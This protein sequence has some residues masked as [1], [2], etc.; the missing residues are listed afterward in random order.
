MGLR[1]RQA[2][3]RFDAR[4]YGNQTIPAEFSVPTPLALKA[5][6]VFRGRNNGTDTLQMVFSRALHEPQRLD[7]S[8]LLAFPNL[9]EPFAAALQRK[10]A[11]DSEASRISFNKWLRLGFFSYLKNKA[12]QHLALGDLR[13]DVL[14]EYVMWLNQ[15]APGNRKARWSEATRVQYLLAVRN[16]LSEL[17]NLPRW[18]KQLDPGLSLPTH[19]WKGAKRRR[20]PVEILTDGELEKIYRACFEEIKKTRMRVESDWA[21][22]AAFDQQLPVSPKGYRDYPTREVALAAIAQ[23]LPNRIPSYPVLS[24]LNEPL[25]RAIKLFFGGVVELRTAL[26]PSPRQI[27]PF[28]LMLAFHT[29]LNPETLLA[30]D[31][32]DFRKGEYLGVPRFYSSHYKGRARRRQR[33]SVPIDESW[34][35]PSSIYDFLVEWTSRIRPLASRK[36]ANRLLIYVPRTTRTHVGFFD[37]ESANGSFFAQVLEE[38]C[39]DNLLRHFSLKQI[40][41]TMMDLGRSLGGGDIR[42]AQ[43]LGDHRSPETTNSHYTSDAQRKRNDERLGEIMSQR[44]RWI[45]S[46][47][48][49][50]S[51][52]VVAGQDEGSATPGFRCFDPYRSPFSPHGKLC[53]AY[54]Y[55]VICPF[56]HIDISST[57]VCAQLLMLLEA[58]RRGKGTLDPQ[59]WLERMAP[60]ESR[61]V[62]YWLPKFNDDVI[63]EARNLSLPSLPTPE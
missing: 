13:S 50:D 29:R 26:A 27:V 48:K 53:L 28:V 34:D 31:L 15:K 30:S 55:C 62:G 12:L 57:L 41:P 32:D 18:A 9:A 25:L 5:S 19:Q 60:I 22:L 49:I 58:V 3:S 38:F 54:A 1:S 16:T 39:D 43:A 56:A 10:L 14:R 11:S 20:K 6:G 17:R 61:L 35:N 47:G 37:V 52:G 51:R 33:P 8:Y 23:M 21:V 46:E 40:R 45:D 4:P 44:S 36:S 2:V 59:G 63:A 42:A 24:E 7:I